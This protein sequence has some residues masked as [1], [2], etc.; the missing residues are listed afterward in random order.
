[1]AERFPEICAAEARFLADVLGAEVDRREHMLERLQRLRIPRAVQR[2]L[3]E[4][5]MSSSVESLVNK[6]YKY[7]FVTDIESDVAPKG[8]N[9]DIIR[10]ISA[11]KRSPSGCSSGGSRR[12]AAGS[13]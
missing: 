7:G 4:N 3:E 9:E 12:S 2:P 13:R 8:L 5:V 1:M 6:E 10:L 11:K